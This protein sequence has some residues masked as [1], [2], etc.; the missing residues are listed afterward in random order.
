MLYSQEGSSFYLLSLRGHSKAK[1]SGSSRPS[2]SGYGSLDHTSDL[3]STILPS[4]RESLTKSLENLNL[5]SLESPKSKRRCFEISTF[6]LEDIESGYWSDSQAE[7]RDYYVKLATK[8]DEDGDTMLFIKII[9]KETKQVLEIIN[10]LPTIEPL[11]RHN[12]LRQSALHLS[13]LTDNP[14]VTRRLVVAGADVCRRDRL[15]NTPLHIA[16]IHGFA[17]SA[18]SLITPI[19]YSEARKN[20]YKIP[21]QQ[22]PQDTEIRNFDGLTCLLLALQQMHTIVA[23]LLIEIDADINAVDLKS[24]K[25]ALHIAAENGRREIVEY[26]LKR[27]GV[28]LN[29]GNYAG[30]TPAELAQYKGHTRCLNVLLVHGADSPRPLPHESW[31]SDDDSD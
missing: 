21:Y 26:I 17:E 31:D 14:D 13:V 15:G 22:I 11:H 20:R 30:Y 4:S 9:H 5:D 1:K 12:L 3:N 8:D 18:K 10:N 23:G 6:E 16:C 2:S 19:R 25:T 24:G 7:D 28:K 27:T 29:A